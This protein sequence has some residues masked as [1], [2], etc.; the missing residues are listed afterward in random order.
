MY[1]IQVIA[2]TGI[3]YLV[4][5]LLLRNKPIH[6]FNR[7][8]LIGAALFPVV[9]PFI[10]L[11]SLTNYFEQNRA[12]NMRLPEVVAT[13]GYEQQVMT[14]TV[15]WALIAYASVALVLFALFIYK[16]IR[17][18]QVIRRSTRVQEKGYTV[19]LNTTYGPGSWGRYIFLPDETINETIIQHE[20]A[21]VYMKHSTDV[22]LMQL[23]RC[24]FWPNL[25]LHAI[26]KELKQVHEFQADAAVG[27]DRLQYSE[28]LLSNVF[29][30]CT[31]PLTHSFNIHPL[32]RRITML[33]KRKSPMAVVFGAVA[34]LAVGAI[35]FNVIALQSCKPKKWEVASTVQVDKGAEFDG[36]LY[37][38]VA[39]NIKY[40]KEAMENGVEG[41]VVI[42]FKVDEKGNIKE[43]TVLTENYSYVY[44]AKGNG[45]KQ[46]V[47]IAAAMD[48]MNKM[49]RWIPAEKNGKKVEVEMQ[50][51]ISFKLPSDAVK[52]NKAANSTGG[53]TKHMAF[54]IENVNAG[55][56]K[57]LVTPK[58]KAEAILKKVTTIIENDGAIPL[59]DNGEISI[60]DLDGILSKMEA[61]KN[62][63]GVQ[64]Q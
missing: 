8:Y 53:K 35:V 48:V 2:Y 26:N 1:L 54:K 21:H 51:P 37:N 30:T 38:F 42:R 46:G 34:V 10:K 32:K 31:L 9:M 23:M 61:N 3:L 45:M 55:D 64:Q 18:Q 60:E 7:A 41:R 40:P 12:I 27:M 24:L 5:A 50:L 17:L 14:Q 59:K 62:S 13:G 52:V 44:G 47:L 43:P 4:Y 29:D 39:A 16:R 49:P 63:T 25:F 56:V 6:A 58:E 36:D 57:D 15:N 33:K 28:L 22:V 11:P 19:L 20:A